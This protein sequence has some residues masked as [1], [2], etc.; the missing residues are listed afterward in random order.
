MNIH[1]IL[2]TEMRL[3]EPICSF[4]ECDGYRV[5][6]SEKFGQRM[7][8]INQNGIMTPIVTAVG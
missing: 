2:S 3:L 5:Y 4:M 7:L 8:N 6:R 1:T